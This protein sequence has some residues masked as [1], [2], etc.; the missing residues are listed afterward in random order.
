MSNWPDR[1][2][3]SGQIPDLSSFLGPESWLVFNKLGFSS[4]DKEW[5]LQGPELWDQIPGYQRFRDFVKRLTIVNDPAERGVGLIKQF[6]ASFQSE[7]LCQENLLAVSAYKKI[8]T[9]NSKKEDLAK[10]GVKK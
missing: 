8:V 9:K 1:L 5:L 7:V 2:W 10:V 6:I 4:E 3:L